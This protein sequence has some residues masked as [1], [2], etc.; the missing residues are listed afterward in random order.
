MG[1]GP[2]SKK[3][4]VFL[5]HSFERGLVSTPLN[6]ELRKIVSNAPFECNLCLSNGI[7]LCRQPLRD[8]DRLTANKSIKQIVEVLDDEGKLDRAIQ[9]LK[10][11]L[12]GGAR[13]GG[14]WAVSE[15]NAFD[16]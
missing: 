12:V 3:K 16:P 6:I 11:Y 5:T 2:S 13:G 14:F 10:K 9:V 15:S 4:F 1:G 7:N 8:G